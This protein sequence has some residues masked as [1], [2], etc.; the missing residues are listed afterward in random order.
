MEGLDNKTMGSRRKELVAPCMG[1]QRR[2]P[3]CHGQCGDYLEFKAILAGKNE[4]LRKHDRPMWDRAAG[5]CRR[6]L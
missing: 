6:A 2:T 5:P 1:C 3:G 4:Y